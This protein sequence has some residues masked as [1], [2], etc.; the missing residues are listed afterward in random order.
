[1]PQRRITGMYM[2]RAFGPLGFYSLV[3]KFQGKSVFWVGILK[4]LV[5]PDKVKQGGTNEI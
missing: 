2:F 5:Q 4:F 1:M 3:C